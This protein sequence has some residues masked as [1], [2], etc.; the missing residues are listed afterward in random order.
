M[1][2]NFNEVGVAKWWQSIHSLNR[3]KGAAHSTV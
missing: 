3:M 2:C 1:K